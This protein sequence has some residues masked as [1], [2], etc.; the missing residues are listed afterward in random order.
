MNLNLTIAI[1]FDLVVSRPMVPHPL[2]FFSKY[3]QTSE[4][5]IV[6]LASRAEGN[7]SPSCTRGAGYNG[8][9]I[10]VWTQQKLNNMMSIA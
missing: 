8:I 7:R 10:N 1:V 6:F 9:F 2:F 4:V 5:A 3:F